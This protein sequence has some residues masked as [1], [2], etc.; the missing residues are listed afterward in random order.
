M[1]RT[2]LSDAQQAQDVARRRRRGGDDQIAR[3]AALA[4]RLVRGALPESPVGRQ[5]HGNQVVDGDH[6]GHPVAQRR[7]KVWH[8]GD[9]TAQTVAFARKGDLLKPE[10]GDVDAQQVDWRRQAPNAGVAGRGECASGQRRQLD[11]G[12][13]KQALRSAD[14]DTP[15]AGGLLA[16]K[17]GIDGD[18]HAH[19][20]V[21]F[22]PA[23]NGIVVDRAV[24]D[25]VQRVL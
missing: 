21:E 15:G 9:V 6:D 13:R 23:S 22:G 18:V 8:M 4:T 19:S 12:G 16:Q 10:L 2:A 20:V 7:C 11:A 24:L 1:T 25:D 3:A 5:Q 14:A 17:A